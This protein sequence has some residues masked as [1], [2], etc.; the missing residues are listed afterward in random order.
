MDLGSSRDVPGGTCWDPMWL[1]VA[2]S[3]APLKRASTMQRAWSSSNCSPSNFFCSQESHCF[4]AL[5]LRF[6]GRRR[7]AR[8]RPRTGRVYEINLD[9]IFRTRVEVGFNGHG[10]LLPA[11]RWNA[12]QLGADIQSVPR[13]PFKRALGHGQE[14]F[15]IAQLCDFEGFVPV[16]GNDDITRSLRRDRCSTSRS[17]RSGA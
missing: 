5:L 9:F 11:A 15:V 3:T 2:N 6:W 16:A 14:V 4:R 13:F 8:H 12:L 1:F 10:S 7:A 17:I